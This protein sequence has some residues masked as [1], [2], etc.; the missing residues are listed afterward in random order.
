[1]SFAV[2]GANHGLTFFASTYYSVNNPVL[3]HGRASINEGLVGLG[4]VV[5]SLIFGFLVDKYGVTISYKYITFLVFF[6]I[7]A[8]L[9]LFYYLRK[10]VKLLHD[11]EKT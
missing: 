1:I 5:G 9:L 4:G 11:I 10:K 2:I 7:L 6:V 8:E 3:R